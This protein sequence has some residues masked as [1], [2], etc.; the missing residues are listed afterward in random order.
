MPVVF[1][2]HPNRSVGMHASS[3]FV[4]HTE[5]RG[6]RACQALFIGVVSC[7]A[8]TSSS[9]LNRPGFAGGRLV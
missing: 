5:I 1:E 7:L 9:R 4:L 2:V 8:F 6:K 3:P